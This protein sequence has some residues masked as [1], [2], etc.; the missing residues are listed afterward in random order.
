MNARLHSNL[1][2][3]LVLLGGLTPNAFMQRHWHKKPL[4]IRQAIPNMQPL[5][6]RE[7]L[8]SWAADEAVESRLVQLKKGNWSFDKGPFDKLPPLKRPDWTLLVQSVDNLHDGLRGLLDQFRFIPDARLDDVMIS[9]ASQGGGVGPHFDSYDVF[10]LQTSGRRRW[11]I[12]RQ[13]D[14]SLRED[15]PL[16]ILANFAPE[17]TFDLEPGDMLYLPPRYA[18]EGVALDGDCQ[19][20]SIGF[21]AS[22]AG[23]LATQLMQRMADEVD[24]PALYTD[25]TQP[26]TAQPALIPAALTAYAK[27]ALHKALADEEMLEQMLGEHLTEPGANAWFEAAKVPKL[28]GAIKLHRRSRMAYDAKYVYLNGESWRTAGADARL[29]HKLADARMLNAADLIASSDDMTA[30]LREWMAQG[31]LCVA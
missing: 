4:L 28:L 13:K 27:A 16:K 1:T 17:Q 31:W 20:Y 3:P 10:L 8:F 15:M 25:K 21:R 22:S 6:P 18:H 9:Y 23:E 14:L 26:A 29:L 5:V 11:R 7:Q 12:G 2:T 24:L 19:T 30:T